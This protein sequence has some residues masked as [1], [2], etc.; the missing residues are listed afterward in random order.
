VSEAKSCVKAHNVWLAIIDATKHRLYLCRRVHH[1]IGKLI[2]WRHTASTS[3]G[4]E[5]VVLNF[6]PWRQKYALVRHDSN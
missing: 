2:N 4:F 6:A 1:L 5:H 3:A